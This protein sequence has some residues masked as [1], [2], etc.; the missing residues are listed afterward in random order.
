[1][2]NLRRCVR[3]NERANLEVID[4]DSSRIL[5]LAPYQRSLSFTFGRFPAII[6]PFNSFHSNV[7]SFFL[8]FHRQIFALKRLRLFLFEQHFLFFFLHSIIVWKNIGLFR[9]SIDFS[10]GFAFFLSQY[11]SKCEAEI[12]YLTVYRRFHL[13]REKTQSSNCVFWAWFDA[14]QSEEQLW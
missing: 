2:T 4:H 14:A 1:M 10:H 11:L 3:R 7:R 8:F 6:A 9:I 5:S 13:I 12:P